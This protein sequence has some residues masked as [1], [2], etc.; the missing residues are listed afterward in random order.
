MDTPANVPLAL[1]KAQIAFGLQALGLLKTTRQHWYALGAELLAQD[2]ARTES[3]LADLQSVEDWSAFAALLPNAFWQASQRTMDVLQGVLQTA[4]SNQSSLV[5]DYQRV[6]LE[7]QQASV[8]ALSTTGNA[9]PV[10]TALQGML[11]A[12]GVPGDA[13]LRSATERSNPVRTPGKGNGQLH[14]AS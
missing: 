8:R 12:W 7:W 5:A 14:K 1:Q 13:L 3:A 6:M 2:V 10:H 4:I 9:M 11:S